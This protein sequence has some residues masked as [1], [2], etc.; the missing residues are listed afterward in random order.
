MAHTPSNFEEGLAPSTSYHLVT[1][2]KSTFV[3]QKLPEVCSPFG[4]NR[5]PPFQFIHKLGEFP[6]N[7]S[8]IIIVA[9]TASQDV[10]LFTRSKAALTSNGPPESITNVFTTTSMAT[11]S[12]RA[13]LP[14]MEDMTSD[15]SPIG[16]AL[17]LSSKSN[18]PRP[19]P[20]E[21]MDESSGPLPALMILNNEG[22]LVAWW[23][24][25]ADS[26]RQGTN[27]PGLSVY[28]G[29]QQLQSQSQVSATAPVSTFGS[30]SAFGQSAFGGTASNST[31]ASP[32]KP[33]APAFGA[34]SPL[35]SFGTSL[36]ASLGLGNRPSPWAS[37]ATPQTGG[38]AFGQPAFGSATPMGGATKTPAFGSAA[39]LGQKSSVWGSPSGTTTASPGTVFGQS[40]GIGNQSSAFGTGTTPAGPSGGGFAS[41]ASGGGFAAAAAKSGGESVFKQSTPSASFNSTMD[42]GSSFGATPKKDESSGGI[43]GAPGTNPA[44]TSGL[45]GLA[46]GFKL[47]SSL[48]N[49][50]VE[51]TSDSR[52]PPAQSGNPFFGNNFGNA[53]GEA[54]KEATPAASK[55]AD[56]ISDMSDQE[57]SQSPEEPSVGETTTPAD[58]PAPKFSSAPPSSSG[59]FGTQAQSQTTPASVQS[60][61]PAPPL[62]GKQPPEPSSTTPVIKPEPSE[63]RVDLSKPLPDQPL[64][65]DPTSKTTYT[66]GHSSASS[67]TASKA[68]S[69]DTPL[70]PDLI[71]STTK[72]NAP[73]PPSDD[74]PLPPDFLKPTTKSKA[75]APTS[76]DAP[77]PPDF[78][79]P[80][81]KIVPA[82][83]TSNDVPLPPDF[84][85]PKTQP[86]TSK[87]L[88]EEQHALPAD[89]SGSFDDEGS[90]IDVGREVSPVSESPKFTPESS[91][92]G[93]YDKSPVGE[94]FTNI[95]R[96]SQQASKSLFGEVGQQ[97]YFPPPSKVQQSP[98]SP[99][100]IRSVIPR[101]MFRPDNAR[102]V[103]AP[104]VPSRR[105]VTLGRPPQQSV[106]YDPPVSFAQRQKDEQERLALERD[107]Q[108]EE[109]EQSLS[110]REDEWVQAELAAEIEGTL[111][112]EKFIAHQDYVGN[113]TKTG[114]PGQIEKVFRDINSMVDTLG[115]NC[116]TMES[117]IKGNIEP[118]NGHIE[119]ISNLDPDASSWSMADVDPMLE[120]QD[121]LQNE[122]ETGCLHDTDEKID[123]CR[124]LQ[125]D[126][127]K[128]RTKQNEVK[129]I[130]EA[131]TDS[132]NLEALRTAPLSAEQSALRQNLRRDFANFQKSLAQAEEAISMLKAKLAS[133]RPSTSQKG[134]KNSPT[135]PT[136]EAVERTIYRMTGMVEKKTTDIDML[137]AQMR[138]LNVLVPSSAVTAAS[139]PA[140]SRAHS[141]FVTPPTSARKMPRTPMSSA[142]NGNGFHTPRSSLRNSA[143]A[144]FFANS[145][146]SNGSGAEM[147]PSPARR[148]RLSEVTR[149]EADRFGAKMARRREICGLVREAL[150]KVGEDG[151]RVRALVEL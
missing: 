140:S 22:V 149:Q 66:P 138:K 109:E 46:S 4:L 5:S 53:L 80:K 20:G 101:D 84:I 3:F 74:T 110:D 49:E 40:S 123:S 26:I 96:P 89:E 36:G 97:P 24:V 139:T 69:D 71:K 54:S 88:P 81:A 146:M 55:E 78:V 43:F 142:A 25:Y 18:V 143:G 121:T 100:P 48:K 148:K 34:P 45:F 106:N 21:E 95:G 90:G 14:M 83:P 141:P 44:P 137:E 12:R 129:R 94:R 56:M 38:G 93:K 134:K 13:Q 131:Y 92:G 111:T 68:S 115:L 47:G 11:D 58:T 133:H 28:A 144:G 125:K 126:L 145:V 17:D 42:I 62:F 73:A 79:K 114:V 23:I 76:D 116:R 31:L 113:V 118:L 82:T 16:M 151:V 98:R 10:G 52:P 32:S 61:I 1:R 85:L 33:S 120:L 50:N 19:L 127:A 51:K 112:L 30:I 128:I 77:L 63:G 39:S 7:V 35:G 99:S 91:F 37:S 65:P 122:L 75:P 102:S 147:S 86:S 132:E 119:E 108:R 60:S 124:E 27:Y 117:F 59:L 67:A 136:V 2:Q 105:K 9:S 6:P 130:V 29:Q 41:F 15:T 8:D 72:P 103:S 104:G 70:P 135:V 150:V 107:R 64:P 57:E 87:E